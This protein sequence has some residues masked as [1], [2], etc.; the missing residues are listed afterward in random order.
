MRIA[1][2]LSHS[3]G[4]TLARL[5]PPGSRRERVFRRTRLHALVRGGRVREREPIQ[6]GH[7]RVFVLPTLHGVT[8]GLALG[9][10][11]IGSVNYALSLGFLLTFLLTGVSLVTMVHT[12][13]NLV[14]L[15]VGAGRCEPVFAG[16][17][18]AFVVLL[19]NLSHRE[20]W[21]IHALAGES[22]A[23]IDLPPNE[24]VIATLLAPAPK[25][26]WLRL[27]RITLETRYPLG[28]FRA[29]GYAHP[30]LKVL[31]YP[32]PELAELPPEEAIPDAGEVV[33]AGVGSDDFAGLRPYHPGDSLRHVAWRRAAHDEQLLTKQWSG[34]G[35]SELILDWHRLSRDMDG[36]ARLA[37]LTGW[38]LRAEDAG[39][40]Y[41]LRLPGIDIDPNRGP[42]HR[43]RCLRELAL[44]GLPPDEDDTPT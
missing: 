29:W 28:L 14:N 15:Q 1:A 34:Q 20:R 32:T 9:L 5:S 33:E 16:G 42:Q 27:G 8:F 12:F 17:K 21:S 4:N 31:V 7:R 40:K 23:E 3:L 6:L 39:A 22:R 41:G 25:R 2:A 19:D 43:D 30:A 38:V 35:A 37:R 13:R 10:M 11:L 26:G 44:F 24:T 36:E 18:A